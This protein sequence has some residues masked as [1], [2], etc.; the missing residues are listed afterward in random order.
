[1]PT[2]PTPTHLA[3]IPVHAGPFDPNLDTIVI[4]K[5]DNVN[6]NKE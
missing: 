2:E 6:G 3:D 1:M 4:V 5:S